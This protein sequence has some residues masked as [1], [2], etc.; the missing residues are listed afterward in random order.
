MRIHS[1][2]Q[3]Y[4]YKDIALSHTFRWMWGGGMAYN[5]KLCMSSANWIQENDS[6]ENIRIRSIL[7]FGRFQRHLVVTIWINWSAFA[8]LHSNFMNC[9]VS[10]LCCQSV[11]IIHLTLS[12][13]CNFSSSVKFIHIPRIKRKIFMK[14]INWDLNFSNLLKLIFSPVAHFPPL[15]AFS[16]CRNTRT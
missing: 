12:L 14:L 9:F 8:L 10:E 3:V 2:F 7:Q 11:H 13:G 4:R 16:I 6:T 1:S 15:F 5:V